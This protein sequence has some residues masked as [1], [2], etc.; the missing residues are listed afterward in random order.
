MLHGIFRYVPFWPLPGNGYVTL[1]R[2]GSVT[3]YIS[4][5]KID[6]GIYTRA[7]PPGN[8]LVT[9]KKWNERTIYKGNE[10]YVDNTTL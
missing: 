6:R 10:K 3:R 8:Q 1:I 5:A 7:T 9:L 2:N 4:T